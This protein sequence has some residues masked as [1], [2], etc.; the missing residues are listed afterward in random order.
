MYPTNKMYVHKWSWCTVFNSK[1]QTNLSNNNKQLE[2]TYNAT[3]ETH[4]EKGIS[5]HTDLEWCLLNKHGKLQEMY[6]IV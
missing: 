1:K 6:S 5:I 3:C 2:S 4:G